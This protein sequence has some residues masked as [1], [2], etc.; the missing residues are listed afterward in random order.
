[1]PSKPR[2]ET[3][4]DLLPLREPTFFILLA[5]SPQPKH[6]YAILKDVERLSEGRV[7]LSTGTLYGA[8]ARLLEQAVIQPSSGAAGQ[9]D[10]PAE[11]Q[12]GGRPRRYYELTAFGRQLLSQ[13]VT[14]LSALVALAR[15]QLGAQGQ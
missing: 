3:Y 11:D 6:G 9:E 10:E 8:L 2:S 5:L 15:R 4:G 14:R 7:Q 13:E 12:Q 1:M